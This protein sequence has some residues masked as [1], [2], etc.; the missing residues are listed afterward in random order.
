MAPSCVETDDGACTQDQGELTI[1]VTAPRSKVNRRRVGG[2]DRRHS[3]DGGHFIAA[4]FNGPSDAFNHFAQDA[5]FNRGRYRAIEDQWANDLRRGKRVSVDIVAYYSGESKR[6]SSLSVEC[7][8]MGA[9][10]ARISRTSRKESLVVA[11]KY[12]LLGPALAKV[13]EEATAI[14]GGKPD[15]I[16]IYVEIGY[17]WVGPSLFKDEGNAVRYFSPR[18]SKISRLLIDAWCLEPADRRWTAMHYKIAGGESDAQFEFDDLEGPTRAPMIA[19][20]ASCAHV[21]ATGRSSIRRCRTGRWRFSF[22]N[23]RICRFAQPL[24]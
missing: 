16:Y 17:G 13:G 18:G 11:D 1:V 21:T 8:S 14:V 4:R 2:A 23:S 6:P 20:N 24:P 5:S 22:R 15:G 9:G 19:A 7:R 3:D 10:K 12:D